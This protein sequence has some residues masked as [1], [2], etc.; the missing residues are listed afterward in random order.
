[1]TMVTTMV[2]TRPRRGRPTVEIVLTDAER[3]ELESLT[4]RRTTAQAHASRARIVLGVADGKTNREVAAEVGI[5]SVTV[6]KWRV[7]FGADRLGG[8][9]DEQRPGVPR[10]IADNRIE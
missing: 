5:N 1:M 10:S 9:F 7:R 8:L 3:A 2:Q 4:R 6:G